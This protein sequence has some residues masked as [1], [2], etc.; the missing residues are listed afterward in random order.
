MGFVPKYL[1][2]LA[3]DP[4]NTVGIT[5]GPPIMIKYVLDTLEK[6]GF[7]P[8]Q[9]VTTLEYKMK[10]GVGKCGRC[11]LDEHYIC[12]DGPVFYLSELQKIKNDF[13]K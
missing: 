3:P 12:K 8:G 1:E 2:Q 13:C 4:N 6:L 9:I 11:N 10:C 7:K 5:C